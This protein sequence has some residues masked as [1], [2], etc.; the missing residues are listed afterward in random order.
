LS[1]IS[2]TGIKVADQ[3]SWLNPEPF[4]LDLPPPKKPHITSDSPHKIPQRY[5]TPEDKEARYWIALLRPDVSVEDDDPKVILKLIEDSFLSPKVRKTPRQV[6]VENTLVANS[7]KWNRYYKYQE[8]IKHHRKLT[9]E[10]II[11]W[12]KMWVE[13]HPK[14]VKVNKFKNYEKKLKVQETNRK[15]D[16]MIDGIG[17]AI[18]EVRHQER[19]IQELNIRVRNE[20]MLRRLQSKQPV[21]NLWHGETKH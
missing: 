10:Q 3:I 6:I 19:K 1:D 20:S 15:L 14:E 8:A 17:H 21:S 5:A 18:Q 16:C 12:C 4:Y 11:D 9:R 7:P 13:V 2:K